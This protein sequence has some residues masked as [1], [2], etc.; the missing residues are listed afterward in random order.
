MMFAVTVFCESELCES[1]GTQLNKTIESQAIN[2][3]NLEIIPQLPEAA[4]EAL[5]KNSSCH[6]IFQLGKK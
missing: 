1:I 6:L 2:T 5:A 3:E 4:G